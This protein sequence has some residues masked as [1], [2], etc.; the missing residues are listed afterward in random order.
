MRYRRFVNVA[1]GTLTSAQ[2]DYIWKGGKGLGESRSFAF[3]VADHRVELAFSCLPLL[4]GQSLIHL[5]YCASRLTCRSLG[6]TSTTPRTAIS[7][8]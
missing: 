7:F 4:V 3:I 1:L 2:V 6:T 5:H 8:P